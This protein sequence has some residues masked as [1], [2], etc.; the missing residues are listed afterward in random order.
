MFWIILSVRYIVTHHRL[1]H[2]HVSFIV[3]D[4]RVHDLADLLHLAQR[5][6]VVH[7]QQHL[8]HHLRRNKRA[9]NQIPLPNVPKQL[10]QLLRA[11]ALQ[12][13]LQRRLVGLRLHLHD[14]LHQKTEVVRLVQL[15]RQTQR[16]LVVA[17]L[18]R[19][20]EL[21]L[22]Q[23]E[24]LLALQLLLLLLLGAVAP[25]L[26]LTVR[27]ARGEGVELVGLLLRRRQRPDLVLVGVDGGHAL[28]TVS[29][30]HEIN[31]LTSLLATLFTLMMPALS[32][33]TI[34]RL[35]LRNAHF[36]N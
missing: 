13:L 18:Q 20:L 29:G 19:L 26:D 23:E 1:P 3:R 31:T 24:L 10:R 15:E 35:P 2:L 4:Q 22:L 9:S 6:L 16:L 25:N 14:L 5:V 21:L 17:V 30:A 8:Q 32:H 28:H 27:R 12:Q 11:E 34:C 36:S 7:A 33:D